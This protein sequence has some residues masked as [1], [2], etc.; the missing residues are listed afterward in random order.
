MASDLLEHEYQFHREADND[1]NIHMPML[2]GL[3]ERCN[4]VTEMGVRTGISTRA[5]LPVSKWLRSYDLYIDPYVENL[6]EEA[7]RIGHDAQYIKA[8]TLSLEIEETDMLFI[9]TDHT[10]QQ[11]SS[12]LMLHGEKV[13][14]W[15]V[16]HDTGEPYAGV[17]LP[18]IMEYMAHHPRWR[19]LYHTRELHGFT[20]LVSRD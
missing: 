8:N 16:F 14:K 17:M 12:E 18:A 15:L 19:V 13:K 11:L 20:V 3:A 1:F 5:L 7:R 6:F 2:R 9:D 10:Y 4:R